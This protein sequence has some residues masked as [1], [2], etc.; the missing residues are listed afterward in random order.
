MPDVFN[1]TSFVFIS[2]CI[3]ANKSINLI[4]LLETVS[5][6]EAIN[7]PGAINGLICISFYDK[8]IDT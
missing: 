8:E 5:D 2:D 6:S 1:Y 3:Y 7:R 4:R